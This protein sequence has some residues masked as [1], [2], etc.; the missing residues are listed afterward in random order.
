MADDFKGLNINDRDLII[1]KVEEFLN[2]KYGNSKVDSEFI[3]KGNVSRLN[4]EAEEKELFL[5]FY[6]L[7]NGKTTIQPKNG[8]LQELKIEIA[9]YLKNELCSLLQANSTLTVKDVKTDDFTSFIE[10][11]KENKEWIDAVNELSTTNETVKTM[12]SINGK[13]DDT[14]TLTYYHSG[15]VLLQGRPLKIFSEMTTFITE[16]LMES[17]K[18]VSILNVAYRTTVD[19]DEVEKEYK[20]VLSHVDPN[21]N[22]KLEKVLKQAVFQIFAEN[23]EC[24]EY[25]GMLFP[26]LRAIEGVMKYFVEEQGLPVF[27]EVDGKCHRASMWEYCDEKED[28][29]YILKSEY[30]SK[31]NDSLRNQFGELYYKY[32]SLRNKYFHWGNVSG[33]FDDT[34]IVGTQDTAISEIYGILET[35]DKFYSFK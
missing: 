4:F 25:T 2:Q 7:S 5:D 34:K 9:S 32:K 16:V 3:K 33:D 22:E 14:V 24:Y 28:G 13:Q 31:V 17:D 18:V 30:S 10:I 27:I 29:S 20:K 8:A 19:R 11:I 1:P 15:T 23:T 26:S 12:F 21:M 35:I 6:F